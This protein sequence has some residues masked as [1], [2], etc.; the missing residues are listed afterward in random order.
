[1]VSFVVKQY[2]VREAKK[3]RYAVRTGGGVVTLIKDK[4][5]FCRNGIFMSSTS[6]VES[7]KL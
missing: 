3:V 6:L 7:R 1:M 5:L 4:V 2:A